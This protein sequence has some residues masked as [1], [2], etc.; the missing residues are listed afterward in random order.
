[1]SPRTRARSRP[2]AAL[3]FRGP[4]NRLSSLVPLPADSAGEPRALLDGVEV[5]SVSM[6]AVT[7]AGAG[8]GKVSLRLP[9]TTPPGRYAGSIELGGGPV[10]V[11]VEV[12]PQ[13]K[14]EVS[15]S[16]LRLEVG[17]G[18][19]VTAGITLVNVGN[20]PFEVPAATRSCIFD[21]GGVD[22]A[23]WVALASEP[24]ATKSRIDL[25]L[26]DLAGSHGGL[27]EMRA[28]PTDTAIPVG[29]ARDI[30]LTLRFSD[31]LRPGGAYSGAWDAE[32]LHVRLRVDVPETKRAARKAAK[33]AR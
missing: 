9:K 28:R 6:R 32:G 30:E 24:T 8:H 29:D 15:P 17:P 21:Q 13:P 20:V 22:H 2:D 19:E 10:P 14:V 7:T 12:E 23:F 4:P 26:D 5:S 16:Q 33:E 1:M 18:E 3:S 31:R 11:V 25:L 27:V